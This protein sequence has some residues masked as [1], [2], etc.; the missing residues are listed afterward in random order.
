MRS[1]VLFGIGRL[2][3]GNGLT[4]T[5]F[6][7]HTA[8]VV[9]QSAFA[10]ADKVDALAAEERRCRLWCRCRCRGGSLGWAGAARSLDAPILI[11]NQVGIAV[12]Q[13]QPSA[14]DRQACATVAIAVLVVVDLQ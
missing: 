6:S 9:N 5:N 13:D 10:A 14:S 8:I 7:E 11:L 4:T 2:A 12:V 1:A 3:V